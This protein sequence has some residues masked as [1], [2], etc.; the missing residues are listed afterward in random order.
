MFNPSILNK[1]RR[2]KKLTQELCANRNRYY[3]LA[4]SWTGNSML[5]DDL[6]Q[7]AMKKAFLSFDS[8]QDD[9]KL[10]AWTCRIMVNCHLDWIRRQ[11]KLVDIDDYEMPESDSLESAPYEEV[12]SNETSRLVRKCIAMLNDKHRKVVTMVDLMEFSYEE[13]SQ[14]LDIPIGTVMSRLCRARTQLRSNMEKH[15][16]DHLNRDNSE[17][18]SQALNRLRSVK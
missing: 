17:L 6:V 5:A 9:Q 7:E 8:L 1:K 15:M 2:N 11:K 14:S 16:P 18:N 4:Y 13:V 3:K 12:S 10:N